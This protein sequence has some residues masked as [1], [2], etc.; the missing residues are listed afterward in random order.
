MDADVIVVGAGPV[1]LLLAAEVRLGGGRAVVLERLAEPAPERK[2]RGIGALATEALW[3]RGLGPQLEAADPEGARDFARDHGTELGHFADIHKL[4]PDPLRRGTKIWQ[5]DLE[6][7][8]TAHAE[9]L[10]VRIL[11]GHEV[12]AVEADADQVTV[13]AKTFEGEQRLCADYLVGCDGG[14]STVRKLAG[15]GFPGTPAL[16][17]TIAGEVRF[18]GAVPESGR[19]AG[20]TFQRGGSLAGVTEPAREDVPVTAAGLATAIRRVTGTDVVVEDLREPR[21]F[22]D[23]A[24]QADTYR[25]G[26]VL[27]AGDAAHVHS[28]SGGQGLNLGLVDAMNLGWKLAA[29][30]RG[31]AP[32]LLDTYTRERHPA[33]EAV[34]RNTRAQSALLAPGPHVDALR[35]IVGELMDIPAV[36]RYFGELLSGVDQRYELPYPTTGPV[37]RHSPDVELV[38]EHGVRT[39]LHEHLRTGRGLLVVTPEQRVNYATD[40]VRILTATNTGPWL[41]RP[42]GVV[43]WAEGDRQSLEVALDTWFPAG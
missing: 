14:R 22:T 29:V 3:R 40:R 21:D 11:R 26:R 28:P 20:G 16:L 42:D 12:V 24:R 34:L 4:V 10:G 31:A 33:A 2:A 1:G 38:D 9:A 13:V 36:N 7:L 15:F 43:A 35:D 30:L 23:Q 8:L 41:V 27:L 6:R 5:P 37:G 25:R 17:R 18:G 19:Y 39:R 32:A